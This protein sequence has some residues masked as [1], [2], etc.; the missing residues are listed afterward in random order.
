MAHFLCPWIGRS[1]HGHRPLEDLRNCRHADRAKTLRCFRCQNTGRVGEELMKSSIAHF[2]LTLMERQQMA[3]RFRYV[4]ECPQKS[5]S[6]AVN[7]DLLERGHDVAVADASV[8]IRA[9]HLPVSVPWPWEAQCERAILRR[10]LG[11][12]NYFPD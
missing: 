9:Q 12:A 7:V 11:H 8:P 1:K 6:A 10:Q 3:H 4:S 2:R 5:V